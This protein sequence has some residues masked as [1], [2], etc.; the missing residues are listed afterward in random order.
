MRVIHEY[1][2]IERLGREPRCIDQQLCFVHNGSYFATTISVYENGRVYC[3][4]W[5]DKQE[6]LDKAKSGWITAEILDGT[7]L[8][9]GDI[10]L[11]V[12]Q[13]KTLC[14]DGSLMFE[15]RWIDQ[16]NFIKSILDSIHIANG[17]PSSSEI[18]FEALIAY[19]NNPNDENK[20]TL[21]QAYLDVPK[22]KRCYIL[23]DQ[24]LKDFPIRKILGI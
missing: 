7:E 12:N 18:C 11:I 23:G 14:N 8:R 1:K 3:W 15:H 19:Q 16:D 24:D 5:M 9:Y 21:R 2:E 10:G 20:E 22:Q 13:A 4:G 17:N 6:F